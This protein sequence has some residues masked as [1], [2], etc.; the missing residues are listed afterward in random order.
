MDK[1]R[2]HADQQIG[3]SASTPFRYVVDRFK[4]YPPPERPAPK[5]EVWQGGKRV[6]GRGMSHL[7]ER[8]VRAQ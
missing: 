8:L 5:D 6:E 4:V 7:Y 2:G 1:V 3:P